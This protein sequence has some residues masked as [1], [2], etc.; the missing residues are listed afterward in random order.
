MSLL[1]GLAD[2][3]ALP[4]SPLKRKSCR[5]VGRSQKCQ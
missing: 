2:T 4:L 1:G 3:A 5:R